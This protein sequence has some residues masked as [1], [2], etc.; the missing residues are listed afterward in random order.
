MQEFKFQEEIICKFR[1]FFSR[2]IYVEREF[3][4]VYIIHEM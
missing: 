1:F 3:S 2:A 4:G